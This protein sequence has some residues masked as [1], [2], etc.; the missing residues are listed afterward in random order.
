MTTRTDGIS[1]DTLGLLTHP[2]RRHDI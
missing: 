2:V 1:G